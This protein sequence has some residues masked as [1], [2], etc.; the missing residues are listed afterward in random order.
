VL[1]EFGRRADRRP[2]SRDEL[3]E[4]MS[5]YD[6]G[7]RRGPFEA[8]IEF[9]VR[10]VLASP[11]FVFRP[12]H[13]PS[14]AVAGEPYRISD[15][16]LASRLSFFLWSSIPDDTLLS[17]AASGRLHEPAT[18][19]AEVRRMLADRRSAAFVDNFAGQWL[20]LRNL[21]S[22]VPDSDLFPDF[23][24]NLRQAF[25]REAELF[26]ASIVTDD[27][28]V[29]ALMTADYTFVNERLARHY[30]IPG[31]FGSYF[32]RV[33][34]TDPSRFGLLGKGAVLLVT[35]HA[36]TT[37]P[38]LRG[39]WVLE[40]V[41]GAPTPPPPPDVPALTEPQPG[42][43]RTM[44]Q[45][46]E[47]HRSNPVCA[48]CHKTMDPIGFA[49]EN[50]DVVGSWRTADA[51]AAPLDTADVLADGSRVDGVVALREAL[52]KRPSNFVQTLTEKLMVYA[53]G[54][55]LTDQ[56]MPT[57]RKIVGD[58]EAQDYRFSAL[59]GG[60]VDSVPFQWRVKAQEPEDR[61]RA[62]TARR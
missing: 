5:F 26:F 32:R 33:P 50:F 38:V 3:D 36:N 42:V 18:L 22:I 56:D 24:D 61:P 17:V 14:G 48:A 23:D 52:L 10:F 20:Q 41:L 58:A 35:S 15:Y 44:R 13:E 28:N 4:V 9:A 51:S 47:E 25:G 31:V 60:I 7:R 37:S 54:R 49:L 40:N 34:L 53:L 30:G 55:G 12:E 62:T 21:K 27:R 43:P 29:L 11:S 39:K 19:A 8:G 2:L 6:R 16:E 1:S 57:I 46:M 59:V 45:R